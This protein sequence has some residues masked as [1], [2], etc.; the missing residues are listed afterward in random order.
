LSSKWGA[1]FQK[2]LCRTDS[3][4]PELY[5]LDEQMPPRETGANGHT[6][7]GYSDLKIEGE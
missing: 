4:L 5:S 3:L 2:S 7:G 1:N 6:C